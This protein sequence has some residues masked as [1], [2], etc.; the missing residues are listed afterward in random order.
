MSKKILF[1]LKNKSV[2][3][4]II[5]K[6][7]NLICIRVLK[8]HNLYNRLMYKAKFGLKKSI[9]DPSTFSEKIFYL[10]NSYKYNKLA[11]IVA[12]KLLV[13]DYVKEKINADLLNEVYGVYNC[14]IS[15]DYNQLPSKFVIKTNHSSNQ[16]IFVKN[17]SELNLNEVNIRLKNWLKINHSDLAGEM[18]YYSINRKIII[19]K[20]LEDSNDNFLTDFKFW[21][22]NGQVVMM[23]IQKNFY[24]NG[25]HL[26]KRF[27]YDRNFKYM[28]FNEYANPMINKP[29]SYNK[30]IEYASIL[31]REF[32]FARVD[33]YEIDGKPI[34]S[35]ITLTPTGG[36]NNYLP[37]ELQ[38]LLG[39]KIEIHPK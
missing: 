18:Q 23:N 7:C 31:S 27:F 29:F 10:K 2:I 26:I 4:T 14:P 5:S 11:T 22:F 6:Y 39:K 33:F 20:Y 21:S 32:S 24:L 19:E 28:D 16:I 38:E 15:I 13:R 30:M 3:K 12:D 1:H 35:E 37:D 17:K 36:N 34:F 8:N 9:D 25:N